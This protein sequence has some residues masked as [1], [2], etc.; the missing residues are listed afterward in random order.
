MITQDVFNHINEK[1]ADGDKTQ[2]SE[3][4][5]IYQIT[6]AKISGTDESNDIITGSISVDGG[7]N[8]K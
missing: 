4:Q 7:N 1:N 8:N 6:I 2:D 5:N 3:D